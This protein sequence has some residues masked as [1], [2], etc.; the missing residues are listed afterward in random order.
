MGA[1]CEVCHGQAVARSKMADPDSLK[2]PT[3]QGKGERGE[4]WVC[5]QSSGMARAVS[6][7][8]SG[9]ST[10]ARAVATDG[11]QESQLERDLVAGWT[12]EVRKEDSPSL[13]SLD[14]GRFPLV[15]V[16]KVRFEFIPEERQ[17]GVRHSE[18]AGPTGD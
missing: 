3:T 7:E 9:D 8:R 13:I 12:G 4:G 18:C 16:R 5:G 2:A 1:A 14:S 15:R 11:G 10:G 17:L 6:G